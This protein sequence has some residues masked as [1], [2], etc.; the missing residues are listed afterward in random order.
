MYVITATEAPRFTLPG[1][2]FTGLAAPSRGSRDVCTW[3]ITVDAGLRSEQAHTL[4]RDE[5]FMVVSGALQLAPDGPVLRSGDAT[6]VPAG[7]PIQVVNPG[8]D[9]AE[10]YVAIAAGFTA[11]M[12]DGTAV[13]TPPWA[14]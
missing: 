9:P 12:A 5:I 4:D 14:R 2:Q 13:D 1:I 6:V 3:R 10:A 8:S 11:T 7:S